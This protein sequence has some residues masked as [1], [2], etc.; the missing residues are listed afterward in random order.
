MYLYFIMR[1]M[2]HSL[3]FNIIKIQRELFIHFLFFLVTH[4]SMQDHS[5]LNSLSFTI[6]KQKIFSKKMFSPQKYFFK[7]LFSKWNMIM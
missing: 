1:K 5:S 3:M 7:F 6:L 2:A 4:R